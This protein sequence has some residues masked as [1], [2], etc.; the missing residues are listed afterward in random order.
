MNETRNDVPSR[1]GLHDVIWRLLSPFC[2][3]FSS[4]DKCFK[5]EIENQIRIEARAEGTKVDA[6]ADIPLDTHP[7]PETGFD[8]WSKIDILQCVIGESMP[9]RR[10]PHD[11]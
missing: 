1:S 9:M 2:C 8:M 4:T 10:V 3:L 5:S 6:M 11:G 7:P